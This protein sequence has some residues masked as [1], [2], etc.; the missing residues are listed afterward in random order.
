M[1]PVPAV[2]PIGWAPEGGVAG[3]AALVLPLELTAT[4]P[5]AAAAATATRMMIALEWERPPTDLP[6]TAILN[7]VMV[8]PA[9]LP[10]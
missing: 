6:G 3:A 7:C 10:R 8:T 4:A 5:P 9:V 2:M 1:V